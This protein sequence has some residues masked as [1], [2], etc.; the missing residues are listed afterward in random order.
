MPPYKQLASEVATPHTYADMTTM[1][2]ISA[3]LGRAIRSYFPPQLMSKFYSEPY[4]RKVVGRGFNKSDTP[5]STV[6]WT[7]TTTCSMQSRFSPNHFVLLITSSVRTYNI[8]IDVEIDDSHD[9]SQ[10]KGHNFDDVQNANV[11]DVCD[12]SD[13]GNVEDVSHDSNFDDANDVNAN[14][15]NENVDD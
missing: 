11:D 12:I 9:V 15:S 8:T 3:G 4:S 14:E 2:A 6:M 5:L 7:Q 1:Y 10:S 13:N